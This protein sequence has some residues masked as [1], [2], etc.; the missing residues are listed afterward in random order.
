MS[1]GRYFIPACQNGQCTVTDIR[2]TALTECQ[3]TGDCYLRAGAHCCESCSGTE[4]VALNRNASFINLV[5]GGI[6][7]PCLACVPA[8][9]PGY[10]ASCAAG[11]CTVQEPACTAEHPCPL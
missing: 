1:T 3:S 7:L 5:C 10:S 11:R 2:Q 4:V 6:A 8:I 9:P